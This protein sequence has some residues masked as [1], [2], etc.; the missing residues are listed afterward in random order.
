VAGETL[1]GLPPRAVRR[2]RS[3]RM[4]LVIAAGGGR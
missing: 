1:V 2:A 3:T 4:G